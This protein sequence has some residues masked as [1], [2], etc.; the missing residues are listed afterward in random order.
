MTN[1]PTDI[2]EQ[3]PDELMQ[4]AF[5]IKTEYAKEERERD[6]RKDK[7]KIISINK[8]A[9]NEQRTNRK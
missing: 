3:L 4:I 6:E 5:K 9:N 1:K 2:K 8:G 7:I